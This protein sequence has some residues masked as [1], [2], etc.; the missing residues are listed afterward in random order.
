[1]SATLLDCSATTR[2]MSTPMCTLNCSNAFLSAQQYTAIGCTA[3]TD[4]MPL[5]IGRRNVEGGPRFDDIRHTSYRMLTGV[6]GAINDAWSYDA[7]VNF[8]RTNLSEVYQ[9]DQ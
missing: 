5:Y 6:E 9:N 2:S 8:S 7:Y 3:P 1:M 4:V